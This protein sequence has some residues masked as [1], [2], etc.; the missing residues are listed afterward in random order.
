[1]ITPSPGLY[2]LMV[3]T[4]KSS[5]PNSGLLPSVLR[6]RPRI[7]V[8]PVSGSTPNTT[9]FLRLIPRQS[10]SAT[11]SVAG[12]LDHAR[13]S[14]QCTFQNQDSGCIRQVHIIRR[15]NAPKTKPMPPRVSIPTSVRAEKH[16]GRQQRAIL[17]WKRQLAACGVLC[18]RSVSRALQRSAGTQSTV[19]LPDYGTAHAY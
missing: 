1:M 9:R 10:W 4:L 8:S 18:I 5:A 17:V 2:S 3:V 15:N 14:H 6:E 13:H 11:S 12:C 7:V 16:S 19:F